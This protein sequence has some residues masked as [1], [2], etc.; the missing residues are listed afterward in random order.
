MIREDDVKETKV[1]LRIGNPHSSVL[2]N[3]SWHP[4][5]VSK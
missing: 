3:Q 1:V 4:Y 5:S 2:Y